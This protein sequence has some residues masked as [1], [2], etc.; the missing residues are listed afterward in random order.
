MVFLS[1]WIINAE[2]T[3]LAEP[4]K[5]IYTTK[6][7]E[8]VGKALR[9]HYRPFKV[10]DFIKRVTDADWGELE[11][12]GRMRKISQT[13][14]EKLPDEYSEALEIV[15]KA[16]GEG[17]GGYEA[18]FFPDF[19]EV[20]G[21]DPQ[22]QKESL[23]ALKTMT[24]YSSSEFAIRP[25]LRNGRQEIMEFLLEWSRDKNVHVR[26]LS[27]EGCR[28]RLPWSAHL[29]FLQQD[30]SSIWPILENLKADESL[31]VRKSVANNLND[32]S[33]NHPKLAL[34]MGKRW[35]GKNISTDWIVKHGLRTLL[36][37]GETQALAL[38]GY[39]HPS[40][41][42]VGKISLEKQEIPIG[43][44]LAFQTQITVKKTMKLRLEYA[45]YFL[46]KR[47]NYTRKVFKI[48]EREVEKGSFVL[49][50]QHSFQVINTRVY[51]PGLHKLALIV[52]GEEQK[53]HPFELIP[54]YWVY[55]VRTQKEKLY[56]GIATNPERRLQEHRSSNAKKAK[57]FR[58]DPPQAIVYR[59][60]MSSRSQA[61]KREAQIKR[62]S[63]LQKEK[64]VEGNRPAD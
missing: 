19:V 58:S 39:G 22:Y 45:L 37:Q 44:S 50:R 57:Y 18:M 3:P 60:A 32:I 25:F 63:R 4:L 61:L 48:S 40:D 49:T 26:R 17:F 23:S 56:T 12:K 36:K 53:A 27:S 54:A 5:N 59:E 41:V 7:L 28:P 21:L 11:L 9:Q 33:K 38:F 8:G 55:M 16:S 10:S 46:K 30:P 34:K 51:Y 6:Y 35:I 2:K 1:R 29:T 24:Q 52:N 43:K 13:M 62:L 64:L 20:H 15:V 47:E 31:Y 42:S 14:G